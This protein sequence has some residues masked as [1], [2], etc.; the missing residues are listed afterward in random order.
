MDERVLGIRGDWR[1]QNCFFP[2]AS[3]AEGRLNRFIKLQDR[4]E[5]KSF[6]QMEMCNT[7]RENI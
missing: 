4:V 5:S 2:G 1:E 6:P 7:R 3:E